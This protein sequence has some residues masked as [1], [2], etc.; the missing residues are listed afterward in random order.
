MI[1]NE[2]PELIGISDR[3]YVRREGG[4]VSELEAGPDPGAGGGLYGLTDLDVWFG[5]Q[6]QHEIV[7]LPVSRAVT[8]REAQTRSLRP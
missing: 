6:S 7:D 5:G 1:S 8:V 4:V 2:L 3:V